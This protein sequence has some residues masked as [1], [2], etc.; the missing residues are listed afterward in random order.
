MKFKHFSTKG[1]IRRK[2]EEMRMETTCETAGGH[3][4]TTIHMTMMKKITSQR[5]ASRGVSTSI[6]EG[7]GT[8]FSQKR[9]EI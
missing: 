2:S 1:A 3:P 9:V 8:I 4:H 6:G 5:K 7:G